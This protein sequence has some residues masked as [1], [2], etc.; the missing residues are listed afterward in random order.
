MKILIL[1]GY[2]VFGGRLAELLSDLAGIELLLCGR[3]LAK[4]EA[5]CARYRGRPRVVPVALDRSDIAEGL[6]L[7]APDL[8]VDASGPFQEYGADP[9]GVVAACIGA[10]VDYIDLADAADFVFGVSAF[11]ARAMAAKVFALSGVSTCPALTGAVL[12]EMA[13]SMDILAV[14]GGIAPSPF[15]RLGLNVMRAVVGYAGAPVRLWRDAKLGFGAGLVETLRFTVAPPGRLPL[16]NRRFSLVDV[17]DLRIIP[18]E[19]PGMT[20]F[21]MGAGPVPESLHRML[22]LLA[23]ARAK[24][25]LPA[26]TPLSPLFQAVLNAMR[27]GEHRGGM[28]VRARGLAGGE[29]KN[30]SWHLL[31]EGDDGPYIPSMAAE[32]IIRGVLKGKRPEAGARSGVRALDLSDY[33]E[34]FQGRAIFTGF[35]D[36]GAEAPLFR[37]LLGAA[38]S[39]LP[40]RVREL[41]DS[42]QARE[43][44]GFAE[45]RRGGGVVARLVAAIIGFPEAAAQVPVRV[46]LTPENG[47]ERWTRTFG[48]KSFSSLQSSGSGRDQYLLVER[49][50]RLSVSLALVV[51]GGRLRLIPRRWRLFGV[52]LPRFLLPSGLSLE[53]EAQGRF[54]FDVEISAP[55]VGLIVAYK[56]ALDPVPGV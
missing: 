41:H 28:F 25:R 21:W 22:N 19:Y 20:A 26:L 35:R 40:P 32:A 46:A 15:A 18:P 45:V 9:Y 50:G 53:S 14:E 37:V 3:D 24:L 39:E 42:K 7:H 49:F 8:V 11:D 47:G 13:K 51:E 34:M 52:A 48:G 30:M 31:A 36:E 55:L 29:A 10:G 4:A 23:L 54:N 12:R 17:P 1:G 27:F 43:W 44:R 2:G 56:G 38:F 16:L 5:F 6:R 33:D